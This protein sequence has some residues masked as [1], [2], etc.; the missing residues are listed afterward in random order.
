M[1]H[2]QPHD[3]LWITNASALIAPDALPGWVHESMRQAPVAVVRRALPGNGNLPLGIRGPSRSH[4]FAAHVAIR[5][6]QKRITPEDL[7]H[8][9]AWH[10]NLRPEFAPIRRALHSIALQWKSLGLAWGPT[11][12]AGFEL[13]AG[14]PCTTSESDLDLIVHAPRPLSKSDANSL[15]QSVT[16]LE[17]PADIRI[18]TPFGSIA[19]KEYASPSSAR[20]LM[21]TNRGPQLVA[22]P[23]NPE[24]RES[25]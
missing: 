6:V 21:K 5:D 10:N 14:V 7:V 24:E 16:G 13:A 12:S 11:G 17:I 18:E 3:L 19:L 1:T 4:R 8:Q 2:P 9:Q 15:L 22:D 25:K 20:L 23:W